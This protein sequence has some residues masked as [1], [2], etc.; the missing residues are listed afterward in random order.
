MVLSVR[1]AWFGGFCRWRGDFD[2]F[3]NSIAFGEKHD[4]QAVEKAQAKRLL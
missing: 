1:T 3:L 2:S 4:V